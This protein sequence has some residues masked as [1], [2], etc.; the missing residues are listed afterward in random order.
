MINTNDIDGSNF[1]FV[2]GCPRSGTTY[3]QKLLAALPGIKTGQE[4]NIFIGYISPLLR[5]WYQEV[6]YASYDTRGGVGL[7]CYF[8]EEEFRGILKGFLAQLLG[9]M[10]KSLRNNEI[11]VEKTPSN[12]LCIDDILD[13]LPNAK[14]IYLLRDA[15][16]VVASLLKSYRSWGRHWA[17]PN[18]KEAAKEWCNYMKKFKQFKEQVSTDRIFE[19]K[20]ESLVD[21]PLKNLTEIADFIGLTFSKDDLEKAINLNTLQATLRSG[22]T[23]IPVGGM[24]KKKHNFVKEPKGFVRKGKPHSWKDD[25]TLIEKITVWRIARSHMREAGYPW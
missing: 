10:T 17:P 1:V 22:G 5:R 4:S 2:G 13:L 6:G 12:V 8:T 25:L 15:R 3:L 19:M 7:P 21:A 23:N 14:F 18:A 20:Y 24:L 11:F 9:P 16:D